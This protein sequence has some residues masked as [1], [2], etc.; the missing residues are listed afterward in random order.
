MTGVFGSTL[1]LKL[2]LCKVGNFFLQSNG[3]QKV[4]DNEKDMNFDSLV[5]FL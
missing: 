4:R 1:V 2:V 3:D 5:D